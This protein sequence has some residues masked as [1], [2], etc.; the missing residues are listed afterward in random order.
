MTDRNLRHKDISSD[1]ICCLES[2]VG[3]LSKIALE[4][5]GLGSL[6]ES[7]EWN[8]SQSPRFYALV[9]ALKRRFGQLEKE[10]RDHDQGK[11]HSIIR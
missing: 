4:F 1:V 6:M 5:D 2:V 10:F 9:K 11:R 8:E 7:P 3:M